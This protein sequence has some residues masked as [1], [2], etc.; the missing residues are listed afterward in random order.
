MAAGVDNQ[1]STDNWNMASDGNCYHNNFLTFQCGNDIMDANFPNK[2][3]NVGHKFSFCPVTPLQLYKGNPVHWK[4]SPNDLQ[5]HKLITATGKPNFLAGRI[6]VHSQHNID[7]WH[8]YLAQYWDAQLF[9]L[10]EYGFPLDA[11]RG[12]QF[13]SKE[14]NHA[15]ALQNVHHVQ[16]YIEEELKFSA[17]LGSFDN[18]PIPLHVSL[19]MVRDKQDSL[20]KRTIMDLSWPKGAAVNT[21][22][23]K[24]IYLG[25]QYF[26]NYPSIDL[27]TDSLVKLGLG[28]LIYKIDISRAF[29]KIETDPRNIDLLGIKFRDQYFIDRSVPFGYRNGT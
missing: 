8:F 18:K 27:I 3:R 10:L 22:V 28:A 21:A 23:N 12:N 20:K 19:L 2:H 4:S 16:S 11:C 14:I 9:D 6:S 15:L 29:R 17:I 1:I 13:V 5:A 26:L 25:T 7:K 24:D